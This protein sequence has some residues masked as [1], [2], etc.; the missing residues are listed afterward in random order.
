MIPRAHEP[1]PSFWPTAL[2]LLAAGGIG[3]A[4]ATLTAGVMA[5]Y[6][7]VARQAEPGLRPALLTVFGASVL[8]VLL[9]ILTGFRISWGAAFRV[10]L[11]GMLASLAGRHVLVSALSE[12]GA[13][14]EPADVL[15]L[16]VPYVLGA[17]VARWLIGTCAEPARRDL[18]RS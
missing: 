12:R 14:T 10:L 1:E 16:C 7:A 6:A 9:H 11:C 18:V 17:I 3:S 15:V 8:P 13:G 2:A 5:D 4:L